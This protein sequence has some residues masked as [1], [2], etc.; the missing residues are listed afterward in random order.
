MI[1]HIKKQFLSFVCTTL[2][3]IFIFAQENNKVSGVI[4][5]GSGLVSGVTN[6][7]GS[8]NI[9]KGIPFAAPPVG[10]LRWQAPQPVQSWT[11]VKKCDSF[12]PSA[13]QGK[14]VPFMMYT[15]EFLIPAEPI[16]EDC[17]YLNIWAP[18]SSS[19]KKPVIVW[20]HG[21]AFTSGSGS[22]PIYDGEN[23]AKKGVV[24]VTINYRLGIF[25][26]LAHPDL[27][28]E[29]S[30]HSSGNYA[31]LDQAEA[32]RWV[33]KNIA[34]FGGDPNRV[35][36]AGQSA[37]SFSVNAL[38]ASPVTKGLFQRVIAESGGMFNMDGRS[39]T[40]TAAQ[41]N[42][43]TIMETVKANSIEELRNKPADELLKAG[44]MMGPVIDGYVLPSDVHTIYDQVKQ[45]DVPVL[46]GWNRDE[47]FPSGGASTPE[48]YKANA[49]KQYADLADEFLN[50]YPG[51]TPE[52]IKRSQ[53]EW[54]R[55]SYFA[56][57]AK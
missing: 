45:N 41:R 50:A 33:K 57:H 29:S 5:T 49:I 21:G 4:K 40:L 25:G 35:T 12:G 3:T 19:E 16:S 9:F 10:N 6:K 23:M 42:G 24:F 2:L 30:T 55:N 22:C 13:P 36:I 26:F 56:W 32:L 20:V 34:A 28:K 44:G 51:N 43:I 1:S 11:G 48:T 8:V 47:G 31:F 38:A 27:T 53:L 15:A 54:S 14:P 52:E 39:L 17:L 37:G 46:T 7:D 18:A